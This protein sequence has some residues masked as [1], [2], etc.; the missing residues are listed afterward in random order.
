MPDTIATDLTDRRGGVV[1]I[2]VAAAA[3]LLLLLGLAST[4]SA[5]VKVL[6]SGGFQG[7]YSQLLPEFEQTSGIKVTTA[8][9][10]S[11]GAGP[12]TIGGQ[13]RRGIAADIVILAREGLADLIAEH[14]IIPGSDIDLARSVIGVIVPAGVPKPDI[15]TVD[16]LK[17]A[18]LNAKTVAISTSTSGEYL[19]KTLFPKLGIADVMAPKTISSGSAAVGDGK[20]DLGLQQV[21]E[22]LRVPNAQFVGPI[23]DEIQYATMYA[24]GIVAGSSAQDAARKLVAFLSSDHARPAITKSGM[25]PATR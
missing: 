12:N 9:G 16:G 25:E 19:T 11:V 24:A 10:G 15:R 6:I 1:R 4:A 17:R 13:L 18:L 7:A 23:P 3:A 20:A 5:Q 2:V 8:T 14:R 21:S 22:V